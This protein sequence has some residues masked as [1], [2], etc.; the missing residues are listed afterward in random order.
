MFDKPNFWLE[1]EDGVRPVSLEEYRNSRNELHKGHFDHAETSLGRVIVRTYFNGVSHPGN[2]PH[3]DEPNARP[4]VYHTDVYV[5]ANPGGLGTLDSI[6]TAT[7][8]AALE[9]H[10]KMCLKHLGREP[11]RKAIP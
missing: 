1:T 3:R 10:R 4:I 5:I 2:D 9:A 6:W 11:Q 7:R 8:E